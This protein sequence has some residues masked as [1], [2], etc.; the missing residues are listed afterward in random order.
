MIASLFLVELRIS[1]DYVLFLHISTSGLL[2]FSV[3]IATLLSYFLM[4]YVFFLLGCHCF[5]WESHDC[6]IVSC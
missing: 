3:E 2:L 5:L 6:F 4:D 1:T